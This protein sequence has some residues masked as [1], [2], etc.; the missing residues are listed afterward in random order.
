MSTP[1]AP[2]ARSSGRALLLI[3]LGLTAVGVI[4]YTVQLSQQRLWAP[5]YLP[6]LGTLGAAL[7][8]VSLWQRAT[9]WRVLALILVVLVA[10]A[11][12]FYLLGTRLPPYTGPIAVGRPFPAFATVTSDGTPFTQ[13]DLAGDRNSVL[14]FFRG[15]W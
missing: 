13:A 12:W 8:V 9:V 5:W 14:V 11:E 15:R 2:A 3:G 7:I 1:L 10:S 4:A 6:A